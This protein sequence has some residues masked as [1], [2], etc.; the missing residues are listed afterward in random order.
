MWPFRG[1][2]LSAVLNLLREPSGFLL[3]VVH[4]SKLAFTTS[5]P[6]MLTVTCGPLQVTINRFHSPTGLAGL[7]LGASAS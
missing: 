6:L 5:V 3:P 2:S 7:V 1:K 4:L